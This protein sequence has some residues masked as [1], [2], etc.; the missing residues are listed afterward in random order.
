MKTITKYLVNILIA[1][2]QL[3]NTILAGDPDETISSRLA[4]KSGQPA[5][6]ACTI[7]DMVDKDHCTKSLEGDEGKDGII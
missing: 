1:I 6:C 2:D 5:K 4:K 7:L 3:L